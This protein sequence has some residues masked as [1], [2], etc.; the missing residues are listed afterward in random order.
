M[1]KL[2]KMTVG[3]WADFRDSLA[4]VNKDLVKVIDQIDP[5]PS[6]KLY[7]ISYPYGSEIIKFGDFFVPNDSGQ[8]V[9]IGDSSL[10]AQVNQ[11]LSYNA[12]SLPIGVLMKNSIEVYIEN[13]D[14]SLPLLGYKNY[15]GKLFGLYRVLNTQSS[16]RVPNALWNLSAGSRSIFMLPKISNEVA[17]TKI[18]KLIN[19]SLENKNKNNNNNNNFTNNSNPPRNLSEQ[20]QVFSRLYQSGAVEQ[21]C[22]KNWDVEIIFFS[23]DWFQKLKDHSWGFF[24]NHLYR[25]LISVTDYFRKNQTWDAMLSLLDL[26]KN[27]THNG[28]C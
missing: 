23:N 10:P 25:N 1:T 14:K 13:Q 18:N 8:L 6:L 19:H 21:F 22:Q 7:K 26:D 5:D 24:Y 16:F 2:A 28:L 15:I 27:M 20:W 11:D 4:A 9:Q 17:H 3:S 12:R